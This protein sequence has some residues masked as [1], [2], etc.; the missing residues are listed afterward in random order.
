MNTGEMKKFI[1]HFG[2]YFRQS[3]PLVLHP[4]DMTPH[5]DVLLYSP[6][7]TL[8][9]WKLVSMG[10]GDFRMPEKK[11]SLG[12]RNEYIMFVDPQED[13]TDQTV[14]AKYFKYI[15]AVAR[16][17]IA[18]HVYVTYGH[19]VEWEPEPGE[20]MV[21]AFLEMPQVIDDPGILR[22]KLGLFKTVI[23]L[24]I[25]L[26]TREETDRLLQIGPE[27]FSYYLYP[28][29]DSPCHFLCE[30]RRTDKF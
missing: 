28:E 16:F 12:D 1:A 23:C 19:S 24:Q 11:P 30:L 7:E 17:P 6:T 25:V 29:D 3:D 26:L 14:A 18:N 9:Y 27:E 21:C 4:A 20:E 10:A 15:T 2:K 5:I 13:L 22:C 8:P